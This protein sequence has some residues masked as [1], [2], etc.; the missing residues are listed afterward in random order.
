MNK[1]QFDPEMLTLRLVNPQ[2]EDLG[3]IN[4]I[5]P[6][7][8]ANIFTIDRYRLEVSLSCD[9]SC[10]Y[11]VVH[12][13]NVLQQG[14]KMTIDAAKEILHKFRNEV[15]EKGSIFLMG[16]EPLTNWNVVRYII[17]NN[18][19]NS[20]I[21]TNSNQLDDEKISF[22][23]EHDVFILTSLDGS[24]LEHNKA[25]FYPQV[26]KRFDRI[27]NNITKAIDAGC[28]VGVSCVVHNDNI[29]DLIEIAEFFTK[30]IKAKAMSFAYPHFTVEDS[31]TNDFPMDEYTKKMCE[32]FDFSKKNKV[33]IDQ[34][35]KK[36]A[37]LLTRKKVVAA[38]KIGLSQRT[39]YPDG[40]ETLCTKLDTLD[41]YAANDY[42]DILPRSNKG[43]KDCIALHLCGGGCPWDAS[44]ASNSF[45]VDKRIC[46]FNQDLVNYILRDIEHTLRYAKTK[47]E[48]ID[49][50]QTTYEPLTR[51]S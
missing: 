15:G 2:K 39:F 28:K 38:C 17:E 48:A 12:M 24:T 11:C 49:L 30:R 8:E 43:C 21:F 5:E 51:P 1:L 26:E 46:G 42:V 6:D 32:L 7:I 16:G 29:S 27:S 41:H 35:G 45:G 33:Y 25:R 50:L 4:A 18:P 31:S 20:I 37:S 44:V 13:N 36:V 3:I 34:I 22:L 47:E 14:N 40:K 23:K 9:L 10:E 19:G